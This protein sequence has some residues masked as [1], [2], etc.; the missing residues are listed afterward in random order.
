MSAI[1]GTVVEPARK[2]RILAYKAGPVRQTIRMER[3]ITTEPLELEYLYT[4]LDRDQVTLLDGMVDREDPVETAKAIGAEVVLMSSCITNV[5]EVLTVAARLKCLPSPPLVFV[6][7][8]HAEVVPEDFYAAAI[9]GV[10]FANQ[11]VGIQEAA[12]RIRSGRPF[13]DL[14]GAA[15]L[16]AGRWKKNPGAP[17]D[18]S[19]LP[20]PKRVAFLAAPERYHYLYFDRCAV[21]KTAFGCNQRCIFCF[22]TEQ[23]GGRFGPRPIE[24]AVDEIANI[25]AESVFIL[26]DDFLSSKHRVRAFCQLITERGIKR[27]FIIYGGAEFVAKNP[28]LMRSLRDAGVEGLITG[29]EFVTDSE[30]SAVHKRACL[31]DNDRTVEICR[32]LGIELFALFIVDPDWTT[33][34][35]RRLKDYVIS[36]EIAFATFST[37]TVFPGT[38]L[39]KVQPA[40][41]MGPRWRFDLLRLHRAPRHMSALRY[42]LW[43]FYLYLMPGLSMKTVRKLMRHYG[44]WGYVKLLAQSWLTGL[45]FLF[46]LWVWR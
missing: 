19:A 3:F 7:G 5:P 28:G 27:R 36:R 31:A 33:S 16:L 44:P 14:A 41:A 45:E 23:H 11:L 37:Y 29:F 12:N 42:Y 40:L 15:F 13:D 2:L 1:E 9:D 35:F 4:V 32:E 38:Q 8:P 25:P 39:A 24:H 30:L 43:L 17:L 26:D 34:E 21:V 6:G 20:I 22:C 10:F 18:P 46:K